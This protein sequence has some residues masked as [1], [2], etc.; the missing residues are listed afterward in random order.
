MDGPRLPFLTLKLNFKGIPHCT[1]LDTGVVELMKTALNFLPVQLVLTLCFVALRIG[2]VI[3][4]SLIV[5][6]AGF[7]TLTFVG[8]FTLGSWV[9]FKVRPRPQRPTRL[10]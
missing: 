4:W 8:I 1:D 9:Y 7:L 2:G 6:I 10:K 5:G 3:D